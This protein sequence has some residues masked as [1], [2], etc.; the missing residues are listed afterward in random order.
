MGLAEARYSVTRGTVGGGTPLHN[1]N[2][3]DRVPQMT[4]SR[5]HSSLVEDLGPEIGDSPGQ[6]SQG[7]E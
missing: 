6:R 2:D 7:C 4:C 5:S 1:L 3:K